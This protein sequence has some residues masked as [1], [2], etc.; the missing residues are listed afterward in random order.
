MIVIGY[1]LSGLVGLIILLIGFIKI[2]GFL[3]D[4][5]A[6]KR[7]K[8]YCIEKGFEFK[9]IVAY[10]N[11]YGLFLSYQKKQIYASFDYERDGSITWRKGSPEEKI[12]IRLNKREK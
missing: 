6:E 11:H 3:A 5:G 10:P 8:Q 7:G 9:K 12:S 2:M 1:I 4:K